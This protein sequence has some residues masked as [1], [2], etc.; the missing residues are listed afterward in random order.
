VRHLAQVSD[1]G[2]ARKVEAAAG[3]CLCVL[4]AP[5]DSDA[6]DSGGRNGSPGASCS[7]SQ[8]ASGQNAAPAGNGS[9]AH[10]DPGS[11]GGDSVSHQDKQQAAP[12]QGTD[13]AGDDAAAPAAA[14]AGSS[15][16]ASGGHMASL[17][18]DWRC[19]LDVTTADGAS[20]R[21]EHPRQ[22][23]NQP[24]NLRSVVADAVMPCSTGDLA[25]Q[26]AG[27]AGLT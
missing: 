9:T 11:G 13:G 14:D 22:L 15:Q 6:G 8:R 20:V 10:A 18:L 19:P 2:L 5:G 25:F 24:A 23:L 17:P 4:T 27:A 1:T 12:A 16:S 26:Y 21:V 7:G 3:C